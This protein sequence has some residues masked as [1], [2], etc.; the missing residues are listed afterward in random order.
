ML[1]KK[2]FNENNSD[3][4]SIAFC[5][6]RLMNAFDY[7]ASKDE[8]NRIAVCWLVSVQLGVFECDCRVLDKSTL[9]VEA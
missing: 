9:I 2:A 3:F 7:L 6:N 5:L 8:I 4:C 1:F